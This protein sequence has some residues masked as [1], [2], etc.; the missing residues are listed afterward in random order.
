MASASIFLEPG[1]L[2]ARIQPTVC[3]PS[4]VFYGF[5]EFNFAKK[6]LMNEK[7]IPE[8]FLREIVDIIIMNKYA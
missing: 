8:G 1:R 5:S 3:Y 7:Y 6:L 2:I 4:F